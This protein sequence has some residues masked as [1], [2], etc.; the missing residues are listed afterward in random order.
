MRKVNNFAEVE[1]MMQ[2]YSVKEM[3]DAMTGVLL[4]ACLFHLDTERHGLIHGSIQGTRRQ[5]ECDR[6]GSQTGIPR[7]R[8]KIPSRQLC[9]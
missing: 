6:R 5:S 9:Q 2:C 4:D 8:Q 1:S 7:A 3:T